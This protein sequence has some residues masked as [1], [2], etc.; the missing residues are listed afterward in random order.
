MVKQTHNFISKLF[1]FDDCKLFMTFL[2]CFSF[3]PI[4]ERFHS[5]DAKAKANPL[6][7]EEMIL[8]TIYS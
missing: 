3:S 7:L 1:Q 2:C 5:L 8:M 4:P 6:T